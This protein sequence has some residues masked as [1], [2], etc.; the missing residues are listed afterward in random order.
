MKSNSDNVTRRD[1][2][3][4][5]AALS[6]AAMAFDGSRVFAAGSDK[7]RFGLVGCGDRGTGAARDCLNADPNIELVAMGDLF[8]DK[9]DTSLNKLRENKKIA[10]RVKVT[11]DTV[12]LG[13]DS[14]DKVLT[15]GIDFVV[16]ATPPGFRPQTL[17]AAIEAGK[18]V[19]M[20]KPAAVDPV[21]IR[22]IIAASELAEQK[23]L[24]IV[25]GTQQ[26]RMLHYIEILKRIHSGSLGK[27]VGGQCY[28]NWGS[29]DWHFQHRKPE[30]SDM[31]WQIRCWPYFTW[32]SGDHVCEQHV[33][34]LDIINWAIGS[35]PVQ[36][37]G[38]GGRQVRIGPQYG[39]IFDHF[40]IEYEYPEGVRVMSMASQIEG[41]VNQEAE[42]VVCTKGQ[43]YTTRRI[44]KIEGEEPY[45]YEGPRPN[46]MVIEHA[47]L[48]KSIRDGKPINEGRQ[49]AESTL[50]AIMGRISAYTGRAISWNW[51]MNASKLDL[52]PEKLEMGDLPVRELP[53]PGKTVPI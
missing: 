27:I 9:I 41:T 18:H 37:M 47:D 10:S 48:I 40:T 8:Q 17:K 3:K 46:A 14:C 50:T 16:L 6:L 32:L 22:S 26:R 36:C 51:V 35:H 33:H 53:I 15:S 25:A 42:R 24:S 30:W 44:G 1:F 23:G 4:S 7:L 43:T 38:L 28:W 45:T 52:S 20:E 49:V 11:P 19:F 29:Q 5:S 39:N 2:V 13:F 12:F 21:G 34:N 31:E